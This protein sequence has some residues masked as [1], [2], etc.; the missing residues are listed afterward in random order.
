[1]VVYKLHVE[2]ASLYAYL[3][4]KIIRRS[5][6]T[7]W[8]DSLKDRKGAAIIKARLD[9]LRFGLFGD[10][11]YLD[12]GVYELRIQY[13]PGYRVYYMQSEEKIVVL[14]CAGDK[15]T[16]QKDIKIAIKF[17]TLSKGK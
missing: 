15:S 2:Y 4:L 7:E 9:R 11:K 10:S 5:P 17:A 6:F 13:G 14:L 12:E 8:L 1:M 16:Q 3:F